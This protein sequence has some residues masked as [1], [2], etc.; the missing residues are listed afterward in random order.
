MPS[1]TNQFVKQLFQITY[2]EQS[3]FQLE[4]IDLPNENIGLPTHIVNDPIGT[5][6]WLA[7]SQR[8]LDPFPTVSINY[9][10]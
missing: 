1:G 3:I 8:T 4:I 2:W 9:C 7:S 5:Y 6:A 10:L